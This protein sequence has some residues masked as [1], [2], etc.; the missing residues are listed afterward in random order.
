MI[1]FV[2]NFQR[3]QIYKCYISFSRKSPNYLQQI[4]QEWIWIHSKIARMWFQANN[5][6]SIAKHSRALPSIVKLYQVFPIIAKQ[7]QMFPI[8]SYQNYWKLS[9]ISTLVH[10]PSTLSE[11]MDLDF[12]LLSKIVLPLRWTYVLGQESC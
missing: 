7:F 2:V 4:Q 11:I 10:P 5:I 3:F 1:P 12:H 6:P 8:I 9:N